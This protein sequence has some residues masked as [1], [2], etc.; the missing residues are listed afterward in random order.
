MIARAA[1]EED[2]FFMK[3]LRDAF[4]EIAEMD[5]SNFG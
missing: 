3:D 4:S 5:V 1:A 2:T